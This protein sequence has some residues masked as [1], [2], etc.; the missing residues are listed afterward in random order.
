[1]LLVCMFLRHMSTSDGFVVEKSGELT[2]KR[3]VH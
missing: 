2:I 1:M 3:T